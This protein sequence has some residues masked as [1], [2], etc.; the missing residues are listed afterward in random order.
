MSSTPCSRP[1]KKLKRKLSQ[2][3][4]QECSV[5]I[6]RRRPLRE[7]QQPSELTD[8]E[9]QP[10]GLTDEE[11]TLVQAPVLD[12]TPKNRSKEKKVSYTGCPLRETIIA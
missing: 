12:K 4:S 5:N 2:E 6:K 10:S 8:E 7:L 1:N 3:Q 11:L 9:L